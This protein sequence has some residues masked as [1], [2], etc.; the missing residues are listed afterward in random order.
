M[1][2]VNKFIR[3]TK[4]RTAL[5]SIVRTALLHCVSQRG[6]LKGTNR[7]DETQHKMLTRSWWIII[8]LTLFIFYEIMITSEV[9]HISCEIVTQSSIAPFHE[10]PHLGLPTSARRFY[11]NIDRAEH[12]KPATVTGRI[13]I[14]TITISPYSEY[15]FMKL[16]VSLQLETESN[17][18]PMI[19]DSI[20]MR[21]KHI[22]SIFLDFTVFLFVSLKIYFVCLRK[23]FNVIECGKIKSHGIR[24]PPTSSMTK[25]FLVCLRTFPVFVLDSKHCCTN[26]CPEMTHY[27]CLA[28]S[29]CL[30]K[31]FNNKNFRLNIPPSSLAQND[32]LRI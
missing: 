12:F 8:I 16:N 13:D 1:A 3:L 9:T 19:V 6:A 15:N 23:D 30:I 27:T 32:K 29:F 14:K 4:V 31:A 21:P 2:K 11:V 24:T 25:C 18:H 22:L 20:L 17:E 7:L 28:H 26:K 5:H 10:A